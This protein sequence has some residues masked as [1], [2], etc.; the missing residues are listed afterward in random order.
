MAMIIIVEL[1]TAS[2]DNATS[3]HQF[4]LDESLMKSEQ[5]NCPKVFRD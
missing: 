5:A 3:A 4:K 2:L 1:K